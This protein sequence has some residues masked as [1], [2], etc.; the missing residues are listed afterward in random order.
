MLLRLAINTAEAVTKSIRRSLTKVLIR[1][2]VFFASSDEDRFYK[3]PKWAKM[4]FSLFFLSM[5][6]HYD[7]NEL[8]SEIDPGSSCYKIRDNRPG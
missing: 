6:L 5:I 8:P 7:D 1:P 4:R 2:T 3:K